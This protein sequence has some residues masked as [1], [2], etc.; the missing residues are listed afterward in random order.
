MNTEERIWV[1]LKAQGL[2]DAGIAGLMGNLYAESG[3]RPNNL[4]NSYEGKL[5]M[6]DAEYTERVDSGSYTNFVRDSAGYGLCQWT[7]W[8]RK[9]AM[10]AYAKKAGKSIGDLEMQLGFLMQ[11]LSSGYKTVLATLK[12]A[13]SVRSAS[14]AVLLQFERPADQSETV[15]VKRAGYGQKY[16]DKYAQKGSASIMGFTNSSLATVTMISPNRTPNRNHAI[17]TITIHCFVGQVTAKRGC[18]VFQPSS[19]GASCNYVVGYD[20]SIGLCVE[21]KDRSWCTGGYKK[22]NGVNVPIRVNGISGSSNDYQ[23]VTI[24]V[25]SDTTHPYAITDKAMTAL[26]ELC[27]DICQRNGIKQLLWSGDKN[28]V[29]NPAKQNLTVHRWFANKACP[30]DYIYQRLGD[31]AAK[32]NAK[33]GTGTAPALPSAPVSSV[34]YQVRITATDLRIRK[35]PGTNTAIVQNAIKPGV[36]TIVSEATGQG[37]TLWGKL[38]SGAGWVSLDFC[39]KI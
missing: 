1:F 20:G 36:Y 10:L 25:A 3:L 6:A 21:E 2:T 37:A 22:V 16:F 8:S 18:E 38:K 33:L 34:P 26:I 15:K 17:D 4:Q 27:A 14:D 30:G 9:E 7:Y 11:E 19:K 28:L 13:S 12:T 24:E 35:G 32:V 29:G 31:I 5:G 39:K 23:A